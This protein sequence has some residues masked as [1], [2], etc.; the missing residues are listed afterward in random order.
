[1]DKEAG[2]RQQAIGNAVCIGEEAEGTK[3]Q[4]KVGE[5]VNRKRG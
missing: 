5:E 1:L 2:K 3:A 4:R